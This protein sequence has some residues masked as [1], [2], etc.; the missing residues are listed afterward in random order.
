MQSGSLLLTFLRESLVVKCWRLTEEVW[1]KQLCPMLDEIE[2]TI[3]GMDEERCKEV[4]LKRRSILKSV[5][6][7]F[8][9]RGVN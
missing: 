5:V 9:T 7:E 6:W 2:V 3:V 8:N 1:P 4:N